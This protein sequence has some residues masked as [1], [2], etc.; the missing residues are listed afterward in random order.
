MEQLQQQSEINQPLNLTKLLQS[1]SKKISILVFAIGCLVMLGWMFNIPT[2]KSIFPGLV[3][4]KV[5]TALGFM[6]GGAAL[7]LWHKSQETKNWEQSNSQLSI[8]SRR[9]WVQAFAIIVLLI[10]CL[11]LVQYV[12][13]WNFGID[14]LIFKESTKAAGISHPGRMGINTAFNFIL[15][16]V[17]LLFLVGNYVNYQAAQIFGLGAF[18][19][20]FLGLLGYAYSVTSIYGISSYT[21]M[22]LPTVIA[23]LL[24]STGIIFARPEQGIMRVCTSQKAG[25]LVARSLVPAIIGI[26]PVLSWFILAGY[27]AKDYNAELALSF[28]TVLNIVIFGVIVWRNCRTLNQLDLKR[29]RAEESLCELNRELEEKI[30]QRT[31]ELQDA[32]QN[33]RQISDASKSTEAELRQ[34]NNILQLILNSIGDGVIVADEQANLLLI[35]PAAQKILGV[36]FIDANYEQWPEKYGLF[37]PDG[38]T[39]YPAKDLPLA[40]AIR[41][42]S[43]DDAEIFIRSQ[44]NTEGVWTRVNARP[45]KDE[46]GIVKGGVTVFYDITAT[47][48]AEERMKL[49][50]REQEGLVQEIKDRQNVLDEAA[51]VSETDVKGTIIYVNDQFCRISGYS[52]DELMEKNH[53]IINSGHH[54]QSFFLDMWATISRGR[55]W[56]GE[57]KNK[58]KDGSFYWVDTTIAPIFD[59][60]GKITKYIGIRFDI[61]ERKQAEER[62]EKLAAERK[63]ETDSL[64]QQVLKLLGEIKGAAKGDLTVRAQVTNDVLGAVVDSFNFLIGSLRKVVN[65]IQEVA[66]EVRT[67]TTESITDTNQLTEQARKQAERIDKMLQQIERM[68]NTIKDVADVAQRAEQVAQQAATTAAAG[69]IAVDQTVE[70]IKELRQRIADT[71]KMMKRLGESSQQIGKI[72]TS[73]SQIASQTNLLALNATIEAARAGEH[74]LGFAVVAEEVRKLAERSSAATEDIAEIVGAIQDEISRVMQAMESGTQEVVAGTNLAVQA[75]T[76]LIAIIEVSQQINSLV[77]N[78]TRA[79]KKQ[80]SFAEQISTSM[81]QVN[82]ISTTTAQKAEDVANSINTLAVAVNKLQSSVSNFR[83]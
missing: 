49:L 79:A 1:W 67:A 55:I 54:P 53:R 78:I 24:L 7:W 8:N 52:H 62:L 72:V 74:G 56:K 31:K 77:Q 2:L 36:G 17:A 23:F 69:G 14:Q 20:A 40:R 30:N 12:F 43:V 10:G 66:S 35:N 28:Q 11:T 32:E 73:I 5:N 75:K 70:G 71:S 27:R 47:Q 80:T 63:A 16:G 76:H 3:T 44:H 33:Y 61:T 6:L 22:T 13:N 81:Q 38:V 26:P 45:M 58:C 42:E 64:T 34:E 68:V 59:P 48:V 15:L 39:T 18:F 60:T 51:I 21:Q 19:G 41:G 25:G 50:A 57:V 83:S 37:L 82:S 65:G 9:F 46:N 4:M 29:Q